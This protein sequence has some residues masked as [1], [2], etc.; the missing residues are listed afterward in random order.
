MRIAESLGDFRYCAGRFA[1]IFETAENSM[2]Q[3]EDSKLHFEEAFYG[4]ISI[5]RM[6]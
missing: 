3:I 4:R 5:F 1:G 6:Y 2:M